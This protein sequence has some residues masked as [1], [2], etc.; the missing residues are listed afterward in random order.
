MSTWKDVKN[1]LS[2]FV[3]GFSIVSNIIDYTISDKDK[4]DDEAEKQISEIK[5]YVTSQVS[6]MIA[7][8]KNANPSEIK[9]IVSKAIEKNNQTFKETLEKQM[10]SLQDEMI[11]KLERIKSQNRLEEFYHKVKLEEFE[12][13]KER[14]RANSKENVEAMKAMRE[15]VSVDI[16]AQANV[17]AILGQ[18]W[19]VKILWFFVIFWAVSHVLIV[20]IE[21]VF[22][23]TS[24]FYD[25]MPQ[26]FEKT[27]QQFIFL[28]KETTSKTD[29]M[30]RMFVSFIFGRGSK[31]IDDK[32]GKLK[33]NSK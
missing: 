6:E 32:I 3:P 18:D 14:L 30:V 25:K 19:L 23:A 1:L 22:T 20:L 9:N 15:E 27:H 33:L 29:E 26:G 16:A 24:L 17:P 4:K 5:D 2:S 13:E 8:N 12:V 11:A 7:G 21:A 28:I 31:T 10:K